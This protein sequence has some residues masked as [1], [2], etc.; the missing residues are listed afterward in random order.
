MAVFKSLHH[1]DTKT[2]QQIE[3]LCRSEAKYLY[4]LDDLDVFAEESEALLN[5]FKYKDDFN[6]EFFQWMLTL[7]PW[8]D[9]AF[10]KCI[11]SWVPSMRK[12]L[13]LAY[14]LINK[15]MI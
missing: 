12:D 10:M 13:L 11:T 8:P 1:T 5:V 9:E 15:D 7:G 6:A 4:S 14:G 3:L 2:F